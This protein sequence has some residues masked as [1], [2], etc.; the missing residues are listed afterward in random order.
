MMSRITLKNLH[1]VMTYI[2]PAFI[3][4]TGF[5]MKLIVSKQTK[6]SLYSFAKKESL[7]CTKLFLVLIFLDEEITSRIL[8]L[9]V[10]PCVRMIIQGSSQSCIR[11]YVLLSVGIN[12]NLTSWDQLCVH[13]SSLSSLINHSKKILFVPFFL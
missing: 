6:S 4:F 9:F 13:L 5:K 12:L 3:K 7:H 8:I 2:C 10:R 1:P 11:M